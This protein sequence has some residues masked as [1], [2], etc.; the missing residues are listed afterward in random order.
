MGVLN[1]VQGISHSFPHLSNV[2]TL[3]S[4]LHS[5]EEKALILTDAREEADKTNQNNV[6]HAVYQPGVQAIL[7]TDPGWDH[8]EQNGQQHLTHFR[9]LILKSIQLA[10]K[11][12]LNW[13]RV[14]GV[15]QGL[16]ETPLA[17]L[18]CLREC[19]C[20]YTKVNLESV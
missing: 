16:K 10:G 2:Q 1:L 4:I 15:I 3:L 11:K 9:D 19:L 20:G 18:E 5:G 8:Q 14:Q 6:G 12:P 13:S 7:D 17:F